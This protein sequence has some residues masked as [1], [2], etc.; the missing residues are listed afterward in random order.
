MARL[1]PVAALLFLA[2]CST[3]DVTS[4]R[5][6]QAP[7]PKAVVWAVGVSGCVKAPDCSTLRNA[8]VYSLTYA[9]L[10]QHAV[11]GDAPAPLSLAV[12]VI[13]LH[14]VTGTE[15]SRYGLVAGRNELTA[16][17]TLKTAAGDVLRSFRVNVKGGDYPYEDTIQ[18]TFRQFDADVVAALKS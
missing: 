12:S 1:S 18:D 2:A 4:L 17:V 8:L 7:V 6:E 16:V 11:P 15:R 5:S 9:K 3:H 10:L 13:H 14:T